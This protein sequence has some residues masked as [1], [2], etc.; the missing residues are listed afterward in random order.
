MSWRPL[1]V[2]AVIISVSSMLLGSPIAMAQTVGNLTDLGAV[3]PGVGINDSGEVLL[4]SYLYSHGTLTAFPSGFNGVAINAS[5]EVVGNDSIYINGTLTGIPQPPQNQL[6]LDYQAVG[7]NDSGEVI[8]NYQILDTDQVPYSYLDNHGTL[9]DIGGLGCSG[10]VSVS[11]INDSGSITGSAAAPSGCTLS[12]GLGNA[13]LYDATSGASIDL[14]FLGVGNAINASGEVTGI[15]TS[16]P[17]CCY[18]N[19]TS[20][21]FLYSHGKVTLLPMPFGLFNLSYFKNLGAGCQGNAINASGIIVVNCPINTVVF[22][23]NGVTSNLN[24]FVKPSDPLKPYVKLTGAGGINDHGLVV[25][26]G[27]DLLQ[28]P[29]IKVAPGPLTFATV[30]QVG[31]TS[32]PQSVTFSNEGT[33]SLALGAPSSSEQFPI[34][35]NTCGVSL[36]PGAACTVGVSF[37]PTVSGAPTLPLTLVVSGVPISV[38]ISGATPFTLDVTSSAPAAPSGT[39]VTLTWKPSQLATCT[40][41][42]SAA[43]GP[44]FADEWIPGY[45]FAGATGGTAI[46]TENTNGT[47]TFGMICATNAT[48]VNGAVVLSADSE[49]AQVQTSVYFG[50]L[51]VTVSIS[52]SPTTVDASKS[53]TVTWSSANAASCVGR[54]G[55]AGD[56]WAKNGRPLSGSVSI[57]EPHP[58]AAGAS[59]T[60]TFSITCTSSVAVV[61]SS[62]SVKVIQLGPAGS[63]GGGAFD[64]LSILF[65]CGA[66]ALRRISRRHRA[67]N[68]INVGHQHWQHIAWARL[69]ALV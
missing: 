15:Q 45:A 25:V 67:P 54:G 5:G 63:H 41:T 43:N 35:S 57:T 47:Y 55:G 42:G 34:V 60:L 27:T 22:L 62:A 2:I 69:S 38:P 12:N 18:D 68:S 19:T 50:A 32:T 30:Q 31:T 44:D 65:L 16:F 49:T 56:G 33:T 6:T 20:S 59:E 36:A 13:F 52:A 64:L 48:L 37:K 40:E 58:P 17:T 24:I 3:A 66:F 61:S 14:G 51:P 4:S 28:V 46:V 8:V 1:R 11:A 53:T 9:S 21:A 29:L 10:N 26:N 23:Y 7:I 39:P